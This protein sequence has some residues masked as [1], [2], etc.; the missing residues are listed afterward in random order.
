MTVA[1]LERA[2]AAACI[3]L[4]CPSCG[5]SAPML[6]DV[7][8]AGWKCPACGFR[9]GFMDG[10]L[11][12]IPVD[13]QETYARFIREYSAIRSAE[14]RGSD[15]A[16][17]YLALPYHD[18]TGKNVGQW[19]M[20]G[21]TYRYFERRLLPRLESRRELDILDLGAGTGWL[22]YRLAARGHRPVA[23]DLITD[24]RDGLGAARHY[25]SAAGLS[26]PLVAAGF[27]NLPFDDGQFDLV[28]FN[29][30]F[31]YS[32]DCART[33]G[34]TTRCLKS[35]GS[36]VILDSP[37]YRRRAH[38]E[39]MRRERHLHFQAT[40]GFRSDS[41]PSVEFLY[42]DL[43]NELA[44]RLHLS[45]AV[46]RPWYGWAWHLRPLKAWLAGRRPPSRF[47]ILVGS[48]TE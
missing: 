33:L 39:R 10:I 3:R 42:D 41:I 29:S 26:F 44:A 45:W 16:A 48:W 15:D 43:L 18:L 8:P 30:S 19:R 46:Y 6:H 20:R 25:R 31:H 36:V 47:N 13:A 14:G 22:S 24:D 1:L 32:T 11:R 23:V 27:D 9:F 38:G 35:G 2:T 37:I 34:E 12:T 5:A 4:R 17:C 28:I 21:K 7:G 40:Y